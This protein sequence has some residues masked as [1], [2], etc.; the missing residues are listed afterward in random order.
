MDDFLTKGAP[1]SI[2]C[3]GNLEIFIQLC[4]ELGVLLAKEKTEGPSITLLTFLAT[5]QQILSLVRLLRHTTKISKMHY[6]TKLNVEFHSNV[7]RWHGFVQAWNVLS[8]LHHAP[9]GEELT[10]YTDASGAWACGAICGIYWF[11][12]QWPEE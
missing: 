5:K 8:I 12:W 4:K 1:D 11:Q 3:K 2:T 7:M 9:T 10:I 6:C